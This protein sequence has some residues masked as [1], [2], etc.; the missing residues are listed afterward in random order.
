MEKNSHI[1]P[2]NIDFSRRL[3]CR[4]ITPYL[5]P[6]TFFSLI[7]KK[8]EKKKTSQKLE[9]TLIH[10]ILTINVSFKFLKIVVK[11]T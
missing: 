9:S 7:R 11:C 6:N 5:L 10:Y 8:E 3:S 4:T 2:F 1:K